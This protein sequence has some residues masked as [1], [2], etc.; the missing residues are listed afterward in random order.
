MK[1]H[2]DEKPTTKKNSWSNQEY[3]EW[4]KKNLI[5]EEL[6]KPG[7]DYELT[8]FLTANL[9][10]LRS[11]SNE[12]MYEISIAS[13]SDQ[14]KFREVNN[15]INF[16]M[17]DGISLKVNKKEIPNWEAETSKA[18]KLT[19]RQNE[20]LK[21]TVKKLGRPLTKKDILKII[22][23]VSKT[24]KGKKYRQSGH[25]IDQK[26][27]CNL[28]DQQMSLFDILSPETKQ[29][30]EESKI[31][32]KA[33][34]IKLTY[35]ENKLVHALNLLLHDK[36]Q[37]I[38][39]KRENYYTGNAPFEIVP[40]GIP[41]HTAKA[42]VIKF[43]PAELYKAFTGTTKYSG[44]D[45]KFIISTLY[46]LES[47]KMLIKYD[48]VKKIREGNKVKTLTDRIEDFQSLIKIIS[49]MADLTE[50]EKAN[51]EK[52]DTSIREAKGEIIIALNPIF[53]D[54]IDTKFIEFPEDTNRRL[55]I[56]AGGHRK[57]TASMQTLMEYVLRE[58][59]AK[60][61]KLEINA[62]NLPKILGLENEVKNQRG[63][64]LKERVDRDIQAIV[65]MGIILSS[66]LVPNSTGGM[67]WIFLLNKDYV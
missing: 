55:V 28:Q 67:K 16:E 13:A 22:E 58:I 66:E 38:D 45:I 36:S 44:S 52:G 3:E 50:S 7:K 24:D 11:Y 19:H 40:Y 31:E 8:S 41:D 39:P 6:L 26:L 49:I 64:R 53:T 54:Q 30:I 56:A 17:C 47:K 20:I 14:D 62:E 15:M 51:L 2:L 23:E 42:P 29:K 18:K 48:R 59:S 12:E 43:K 57:V 61:Y 10:V 33:E 1:A 27:K 21:E 60:R 32:V 46:Q 37:N 63:K 25:L 4:L 9:E 34:G 5:P 65:N 35:A